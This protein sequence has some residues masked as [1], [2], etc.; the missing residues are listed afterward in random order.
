MSGAGSKATGRPK[1]A[2]S[3][4][5]LFFAVLAVAVFF[6]YSVGKDMALRDNARDAAILA[7]GAE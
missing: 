7:G 1:K 6:G 4:L 2:M 3:A 5:G